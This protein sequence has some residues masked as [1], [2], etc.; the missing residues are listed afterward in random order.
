MRTPETVSTRC[1]VKR[2]RASAT[3]P[4][5][6]CEIR[7]KPQIPSSSGGTTAA[8]PRNSVAEMAWISTAATPHR[9][10]RGQQL[11]RPLDQQRLERVDVAVHARDD[12]AGLGAVQ[13][14][15]DEPGAQEHRSHQQGLERHDRRQRAAHGAQQGNEPPEHPRAPRPCGRALFSSSMSDSGCC[16]RMSPRAISPSQQFAIGPQAGVFHGAVRRPRCAR[17]PGAA[18]GRLQHGG[19]LAPPHQDGGASARLVPQRA[20][21]A[22]HALLGQRVQ[23]AGGVVEREQPRLG[24]QCPCEGQALPL[25]AGQKVTPR[26]PTRVASPS[27]K[28]ASTS[29]ARPHVQRLGEIRLGGLGRRGAPGWLPAFS[30]NGENLLRAPPGP[31]DAVHPDEARAG[32]PIRFG[33]R[34]R[35]PDRHRRR[36]GAAAGSRACSC[37]SRSH[38]RWRRPRRAGRSASSR[39]GWPCRPREPARARLRTADRGAVPGRAPRRAAPR[40]RSRPG[41]DGRGRIEQL[42]DAGGRRSRVREDL[43]HT[44][45]AFGAEDQ[46]IGHQQSGDQLAAMQLPAVDQVQSED[47]YPDLP[48]GDDGLRQ[49]ERA[50][51]RRR[52]PPWPGA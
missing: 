24:E 52:A 1:A 10:Q 4:Q 3:R 11:G 12:A 22:Q 5:F 2:A 27:C 20:Q 13:R 46:H 7:L 38:P 36:A 35:A 37:P 14:R 50:C 49:G 39:R 51:W 29:S 6:F 41:G 8:R 15:A 28:R 9:G 31:R 43:Q 18:R 23:R 16:P 26:S 32:Q 47:Q 45:D 25:A 30:E 40:E 33:H 44:A 42:P 17:P 48:E 21:A 34:R 19:Q